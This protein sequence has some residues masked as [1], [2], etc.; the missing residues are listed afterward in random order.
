MTTEMSPWRQKDLVMKQSCKNDRDTKLKMRK[1][2]LKG[3]FFN[4]SVNILEENAR[5]KLLCS[6]SMLI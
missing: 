3:E 4:R 6:E 2:I 1:K 5:E